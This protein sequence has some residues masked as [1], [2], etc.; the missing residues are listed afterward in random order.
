[1]TQAETAALAHERERARWRANSRIDAAC[2]EAALTSAR[3]YL[4]HVEP[5]GLGARP[6]QADRRPRGQVRHAAHRAARRA[7]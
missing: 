7:R 5:A 4:E 2:V 6:A 1:M 3:Q